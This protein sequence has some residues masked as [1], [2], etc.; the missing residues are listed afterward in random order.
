MQERAKGQNTKQ[1]SAQRLCDFFGVPAAAAASHLS[2]RVGPVIAQGGTVFH[3][4]LLHRQT[5]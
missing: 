2:A 4:A 5:D 3:E 1:E